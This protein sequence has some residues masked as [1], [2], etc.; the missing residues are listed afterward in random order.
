MYGC[1]TWMSG[2]QNTSERGSYSNPPLT[3]RFRSGANFWKINND[4]SFYMQGGRANF[5]GNCKHNY[6]QI[7]SVLSD[8]WR[9]DGISWNLI[10]GNETLGLLGDFE[11][12]IL[13]ARAESFTWVDSSNNLWLYGG[14]GYS[15]S[16]PGRVL[17][18][19]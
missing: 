3:P 14:T 15:F 17:N 16:S 8:F 19:S 6:L 7:F 12:G 4:N 2:S 11:L 5:D 10:Y 18:E 1:W 9:F 13:S